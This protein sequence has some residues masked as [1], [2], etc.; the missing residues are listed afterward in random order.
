[1]APADGIGDL[2]PIRSGGIHGSEAARAAAS[3]DSVRGNLLGPAD[4]DAVR[5]WDGS[6]K[7]GRH[8]EWL[9]SCCVKQHAHKAFIAV[10]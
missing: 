4:G 5:S 7:W 3:G 6:V 10:L 1:M 9:S 8:T 2:W